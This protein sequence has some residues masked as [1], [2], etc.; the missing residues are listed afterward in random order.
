[1]ITKKEIY[2][3][4]AEW[5]AKR[6]AKNSATGQLNGMSEDLTEAIERLCSLRHELH[7]SEKSIFLREADTLS[8]LVK[9]NHTLAELGHVM[10]F[11]PSDVSDYIDIDSDDVVY[12]Y[13]E[14]EGI[15]VGTDEFMEFYEEHYTRV[16]GELNDLN[17]K[18]EGYLRDID[19]RYGTSYCPTGYTR[20]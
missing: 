5:A 11:I 6:H 16:V 15:E 9:I 1:M 18:I 10:T 20:L 19:N 12:F 2:A 14:E 7:T 4:K 17:N 3:R 8:Q 13:A